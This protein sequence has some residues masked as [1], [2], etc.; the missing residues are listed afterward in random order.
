VSKP[1]GASPEE[2]FWY[3]I[4]E[5]HNMYLRR[6]A[7]ELPPWT[8][9]PIL[10]SFRFCNPFRENDKV[11]TWLREHF[12]EPHA[13]APDDI[14]AFN[15]VWFRMFNRI[16]T[17]EHLGFLNTWEPTSVIATLTDRMKRG[18]PVFTGAYIVRSRYGTKDSKESKI[19]SVVNDILT[20]IWNDR[21][22]LV[23]QIRTLNSLEGVTRWLTR[24]KYVGDFMAFEMVTDMRHTKLLNQA[25]DIMTWANPGPGAY[26]G[27]RRIFGEPRMRKDGQVEQYLVRTKMV[28]LMRELLSR[29]P[30]QMAGLVNFPVVEMRD[31]EHSLCE[32]DKYSRVVLHEGRPRQK[33][34]PPVE[35]TR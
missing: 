11:T 34:A 30:A 13:D 19:D 3:W 10:Q 5:R 26:R 35:L 18:I 14:L 31:I 32:F 24:Y 21:H 1:L 27:L 23:N 33:Y 28:E 17:A 2:T 16:E 6:K 22:E 15:M 12:R 29:A 8:T 7:G 4:R 20:P 25:T 9:D